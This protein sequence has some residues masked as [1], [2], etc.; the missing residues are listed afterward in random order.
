MVVELKAFSY[1]SQFLKHCES[2]ADIGA[3]TA[4]F[5]SALRFLLRINDESSEVCDIE[6]FWQS[7][8]RNQIGYVVYRLKPK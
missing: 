8:K 4:V 2:S 5:H 3:V 7:G 6:N 1:F